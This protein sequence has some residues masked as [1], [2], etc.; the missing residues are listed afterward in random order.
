MRSLVDA[1]LQRWFTADFAAR[2]PERIQCIRELI[3]DTDPGGYAA[4]G[5]AL[6]TADIAGGI[7]RIKCPVRV[8]AGRYDPAT[9]PAR[10]EEIV[11]AISGS[12]LVTLEAAHITP[13]E[14]AKPFGVLLRDFVARHGHGRVN[15]RA[16]P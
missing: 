6:R 5:D 4:C 16:A 2:H 7:D 3:L 9:P 13:I 12:E 8:I 11:R 14:A 15:G 1:T 10:S